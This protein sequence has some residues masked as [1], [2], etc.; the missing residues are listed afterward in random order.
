MSEPYIT[1]HTDYVGGHIVFILN[2]PMSYQTRKDW[3]GTLALWMF[4]L[5]G[6]ALEEEE[7]E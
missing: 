2:I 4:R 1:R 7:N 3:R 6:R 5:I